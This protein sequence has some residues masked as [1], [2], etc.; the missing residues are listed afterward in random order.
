[1]IF[2][3]LSVKNHPVSEVE[4]HRALLLETLQHVDQPVKLKQV[5]SAKIFDK[6]SL[7]PKKNTKKWLEKKNFGLET[8]LQPALKKRFKIRR[9]P[10]NRCAHRL[11]GFT[12]LEP[13]SPNSSCSA[14]PRTAKV[15]TAAFVSWLVEKEPVS[16]R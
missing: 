12:A 5:F 11:E 6:N 16:Y 14:L 4:N 10:L 7:D 15:F 3:Y 9:K 8:H 1:M 13:M 2:A